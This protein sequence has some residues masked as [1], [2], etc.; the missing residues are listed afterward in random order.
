MRRA[1]IAL[2]STLMGIGPLLIG[3]AAFGGTALAASCLDAG[4]SGMTAAVIAS[5]GD[6]ITGAIDAT[7]C[8]IGVYVGP[9]VTWV[10]VDGATISGATLHGVFAQDTSHV[11]VQNSNVS[12]NVPEE[13]FPETKAIQ[14]TGT[15]FGLIQN[16]VVNNNGGGGI[17]VT[18]DGALV[19]PDPN[20][21]TQTVSISPG[22]PVPGM[23]SPGNSNR[24]LNNWIQ[25]NTN[26]CGIVVSSYIPG[27]GVSFNYISGNTVINNPAGI[28]IA[29]DMPDTTVHENTASFNTSYGSGFADMIVHSNA[30]GDVV[31]NTH[32][33]F[34]WLGSD[35]S[36]HPGIGTIIG[37]EAPGATL[38]GTTLVGN[39]VTN[40]QIGLALNGVNGLHSLGNKYTNVGVIVAPEPSE[41]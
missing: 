41:E 31:T 20:D 21:S 9:G 11:I 35:M 19:L 4:T 29:A 3:G 8:D 18:D 16:N 1:I 2:L 6:T 34:N 24:I 13:I 32:I 23:A 25:D 40:E 22:G 30:P 39:H 12:N 26:G 33:L 28:V 5:S 38:T 37:A 10:T 36:S 15:S 27:E 7:G 17:A 14:L